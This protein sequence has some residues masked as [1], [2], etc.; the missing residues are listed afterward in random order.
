MFS[1]SRP[2]V[3][4]CQVGYL[5]PSLLS[6]CNGLPQDQQYSAVDQ[7]IADPQDGQVMAVSRVIVEVLEGC[8]CLSRRRRIRSSVFSRCRSSRASMS[9]AACP[10]MTAT[11]A[12]MLPETTSLPCQL[13]GTTCETIYRSCSEHAQNLYEMPGRDQNLHRRSPQS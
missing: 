3:S 8:G 9:S 6:S 4:Y 11:P 2:T 13:I 1:L 10:G 7:C 12:K 5:S